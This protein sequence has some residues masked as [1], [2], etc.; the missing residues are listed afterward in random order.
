MQRYPWKLALDLTVSNPPLLYNVLLRPAVALIL[1]P[2]FF[3]L[4]PVR[5]AVPAEL[6][7]VDLGSSEAAGSELPPTICLPP[8]TDAPFLLVFS[9]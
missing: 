8:T 2:H 7:G 5:V 6:S 9:S 4:L 1:G 3:P